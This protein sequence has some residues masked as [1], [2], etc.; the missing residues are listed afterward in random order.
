MMLVSGGRWYLPLLR[1]LL[2]NRL[3]VSVK[4]HLIQFRIDITYKYCLE[5]AGERN[6]KYI[7][8][9]VTFIKGSRKKPDFFNQ[10]VFFCPSS[11]F[12]LP[13]CFPSRPLRRTRNMG[14]EVPS[15]QNPGCKIMTFR[16]TLEEFR[17]FGKY[18]AYMESQGAHRAGLAKVS[19]PR[20]GS[21]KL[22][23]GCL[24]EALLYVGCLW[25]SFCFHGVT[26]SLFL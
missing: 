5:G 21:G 18:I 16:P 6:E 7:H 15:P 11:Y 1:A 13:F 22:P 20:W 9:P 4:A 26:Q 25:S 17:D 24:P 3:G 2:A 14:S 12:S 23:E 8:A 19:C 10:Y